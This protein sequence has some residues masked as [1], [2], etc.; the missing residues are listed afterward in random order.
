[1][2]DAYICDAIR[3]PI[4]RYG[5]SLAGVRTDE[6]GAVPMRALV[7]R[8]PAVDWSALD[9][10]IYGCANQAGEDNRNVARMAA[11]LAGLP[12]GTAG[13]T[14]NR[15]CGSGLDAVAGAARMIRTGEADLVI[16]GG[17]ESMSRAPYVVA[18]ADT[19]YSR[20]VQM[21][22]TTIGWRFVNAAFRKQFGVDSMPETAENVAEQFAISRVDQ[23]SFALRSTSILATSARCGWFSGNAVTS[24]TVPT[25]RPASSSATSTT[26][27]SRITLA[28]TPVQKACTLSRVSG[29]MKPTLASASTQS[30]STSAR[31]STQRV[32]SSAVRR[33]IRTPAL[34]GWRGVAP[35]PG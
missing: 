18:K 1:M 21:Y 23:D 14:L 30:S 19:P 35:L 15:L 2:T 28:A 32:A 25:M 6:L 20:D 31:A 12:V 11:L 10:V 5:G 24:W 4:G 17:V 22:D 26:R 9:D 34:I 29:C 13:V 3:T 33:R 27:S 8:N 16:A 7:A